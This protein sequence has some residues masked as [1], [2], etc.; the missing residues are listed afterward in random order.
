[1]RLVKET[2]DKKQKETKDQK[3]QQ[4]IPPDMTDYQKSHFDV[5]IQEKD[6]KESIAITNPVLSNF[7]NAKE[8]MSLWFTS[9]RKKIRTPY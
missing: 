7:P 6:L 9:E 8:W 4:E 3:L 1:M 5:F 2:Q